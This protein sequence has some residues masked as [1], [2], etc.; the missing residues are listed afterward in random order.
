[1]TSDFRN[2]LQRARL[3]PMISPRR[4]LTNRLAAALALAAAAA[5]LSGATCGMKAGKKEQEQA[6]IRYDLGV[7]A[8]QN[9]DARGALA[10]YEKAIALDPS[11]DLAHNALGLTYHLSFGEVDKAIAHYRRALELNPKFSEAYTN[12]GNVYLSLQRY[13]EAA[14]LYEKALSDILYKTPYIAENNLGWCYYKRGQTQAAV[15]HIKTALIANPKFCLGYKN[16]GIIY[17]EAG[18]PDKAA[19]S[20]GR[21]AKSCPNLADAHHRYGAALL[22]VDDSAGA[23]REFSTCVL[24]GKDEPLGEECQKILGL[25]DQQ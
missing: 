19:E 1:M 11:F 20:F 6:A 18:A 3:N 21:Y 4:P 25:L 7:Q 2:R 24:K 23:R 15:D 12:L 22:K 16:L 5:A 9:G 17:S 13:T 14:P 10:E 8:M